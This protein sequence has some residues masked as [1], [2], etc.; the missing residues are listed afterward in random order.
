MARVLIVDDDTDI[1]EMLRDGLTD[2]GH[3]VAEA[4]DGQSAL[5]LLTTTP[6]RWVVLLDYRMP[7][8]DGPGVLKAVAA[9]SRLA[10]QH[11]YIAMVATT[12][13]DDAVESLRTALGAPLLPK[14]FDMDELLDAIAQVEARLW[15]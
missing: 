4:P 6:H 10:R 9:D 15:G 13:L 8:L 12:H 5:E 2:E 14:P 1:R 11:A 3:E 7:V